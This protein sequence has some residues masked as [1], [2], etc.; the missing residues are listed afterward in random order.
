MLKPLQFYIYCCDRSSNTI[1][2]VPLFSTNT[3]PIRSKQI[4]LLRALL[5]LYIQKYSLNCFSAT[6][7]FMLCN[8]Q[9]EIFH[10]RKMKYFLGR[11]MGCKFLCSMVLPWTLPRCCQLTLLVHSNV[12]ISHHPSASSQGCSQSL[13]CTS[14]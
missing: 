9:V 2:I 14:L 1:F 4:V 6:T 3:E 13:L 8:L 10:G 11:Y 5:P 7:C 12:F